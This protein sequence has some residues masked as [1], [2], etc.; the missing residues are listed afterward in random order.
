MTARVVEW[1]DPKQKTRWVVTTPTGPKAS[2]TGRLTVNILFDS[3]KT[4]KLAK[5]GRG[6]LRYIPSSKSFEP[7]DEDRAWAARAF[8]DSDRSATELQLVENQAARIGQQC[9]KCQVASQPS[10]SDWA[11]YALWCA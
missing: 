4:S 9:R 6:L 7:S 2:L 10:A 8:A 3:S 1:F 5:F 11:D